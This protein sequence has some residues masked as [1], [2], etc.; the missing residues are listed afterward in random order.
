MLISAQNKI[1]L[2]NKATIPKS[3]SEFRVVLGID[4]LS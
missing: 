3:F 1:G 2:H 4:L